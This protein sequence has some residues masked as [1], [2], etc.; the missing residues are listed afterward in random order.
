VGRRS[1]CSDQCVN[2]WNLRRDPKVQTRF[3]LERDHGVCHLC[4]LD[5]LTLMAEL[6]E[7]RRRDRRERWGQH[8]A[9]NVEGSMP[10]DGYLEKLSAR[11]MELEMP[12]HLR[13]LC[14]RLWEADH[15][16]PV[17]EGGGDCGP[18][19]LRTLCWA[20]HRKETAGLKKR[21][22]AKRKAEAT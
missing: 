10:S 15:I 12:L 5:C 2:N 3:L 4:G 8:N 22:A 20:C 14:R 6:R 17:S 11:L 19:N 18:E 9:I 7:L 1:F 21:L 13:D 16:V